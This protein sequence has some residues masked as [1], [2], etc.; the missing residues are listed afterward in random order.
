M[1]IPPQAGL[2]NSCFCLAI[3]VLCGQSSDAL[4]EPHWPRCDGS[5]TPPHSAASFRTHVMSKQS[6]KSEDR[7]GPMVALGMSVGSAL[8]AGAGAVIGNVALGAVI[9][10]AVGGGI[11][12]FVLV[13]R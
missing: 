5:Y 7:N 4:G 10:M 13:M 9:G 3:Q 1:V 11:F 8:G 6:P 12:Y 2:S